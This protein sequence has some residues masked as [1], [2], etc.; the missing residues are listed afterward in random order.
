MRLL[1]RTDLLEKEDLI[2]ALEREDA[3]EP[4]LTAPP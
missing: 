3:G 2:Q 4:P 1:G